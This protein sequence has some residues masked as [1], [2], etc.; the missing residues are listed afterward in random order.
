MLTLAGV[1]VV[2]GLGIVMPF[3]AAALAALTLFVL[4]AA[5]GAL[6]TA[7]AFTSMGV[8]GEG[9]LREGDDRHESNHE[10]GYFFHFC[11]SHF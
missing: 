4:L 5:M 11:I 1:S 7:L 6:L 10:T 2:A 3:G 8:G 9:D